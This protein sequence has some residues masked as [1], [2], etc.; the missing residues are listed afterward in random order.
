MFAQEREA[1]EAMKRNPEGKSQQAI[2]RA[3]A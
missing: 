3:E 1:S 2:L